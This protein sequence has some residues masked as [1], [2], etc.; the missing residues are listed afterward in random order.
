M[1]DVLSVSE[2]CRDENHFTGDSFIIFTVLKCLCPGLC[3]E[4]RTDWDHPPG[5]VKQNSNI[6]NFPAASFVQNVI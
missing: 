1:S 4:S 5:E 3:R 6:I 2:S